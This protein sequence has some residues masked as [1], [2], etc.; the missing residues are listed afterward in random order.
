MFSLKDFN[1]SFNTLI[2][3][4]C[5]IAFIFILNTELV[6][7]YLRLIPGLEHL[8]MHIAKFTGLENIIPSQDTEIKQNDSKPSIPR[9]NVT[10]SMK[11]IIASNQQWKCKQCQSILDYTYE[12]DHINPLYKGGSNKMSN[13]QALCRPCH[14]KKT[15]NEKN[16]WR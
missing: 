14:G 5:V 7:N 8:G 1:F 4:V 15:I 3:I 6:K 10:E 13:L 2:K 11:K 16:T 9:R 12:I